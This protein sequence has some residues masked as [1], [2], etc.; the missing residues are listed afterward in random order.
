MK[1]TFRNHIFFLFTLAALSFSLN[2]FSQVSG[3][4]V[5]KGLV[6]DALTGYPIPFASVFLKGTTVGT[7]TDDNGKYRI[8]T[9]VAATTISFSFIG[10]Q[11]ESREII[12][13]VEQTVDVRMSLSSITLDEVI[14]KAKKKEY[15][16]KNNP[17]VELIEKVVEKKE[18]NRPVLMV[19]KPI[20][21]AFHFFI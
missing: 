18:Q 2:S 14:V 1:I 17:A 13:G 20:G 6:V 12:T 16:N 4:T 21:P 19:G 9:S 8:E 3:K 10:Y 5:I 7:L 15:K 11:A